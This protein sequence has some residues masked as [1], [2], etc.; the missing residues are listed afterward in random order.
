MLYIDDD[1]LKLPII[2]FLDSELFLIYNRE[3]VHFDEW[4]PQ[5]IYDDVIRSKQQSCIS[6]TVDWEPGEIKTSFRLQS[7]FLHYLSYLV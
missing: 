3:A 6:E 4:M 1:M 2:K 7:Y 5:H